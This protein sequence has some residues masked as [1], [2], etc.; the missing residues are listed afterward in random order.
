M[1]EEAEKG[2]AEIAEPEQTAEKKHEISSE[3]HVKPHRLKHKPQ[4]MEKAAEE[5]VK[6]IL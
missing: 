4:K 1:S 2:P 6:E 5:M 3:T